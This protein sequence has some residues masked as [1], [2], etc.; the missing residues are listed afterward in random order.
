MYIYI[1]HISAY[2]FK[3]NVLY[4]LLLWTYRIVVLD[5]GRIAEFD[6]PGDLIADRN[7]QIFFSMAKNAGLA[8]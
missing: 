8:A 7:S 1:Y 4:I 5:N 6:S 3:I 2:T